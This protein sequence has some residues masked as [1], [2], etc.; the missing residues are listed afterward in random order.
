MH[1]IKL[2]IPDFIYP[3]I[4]S[5]LK[6]YP[7]ANIVEDSVNPDFIV[8]NMDEAKRRVQ[9]ARK[10]DNFIEEKQFWEEID[11]NIFFFSI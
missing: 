1:T 11:K 5:L 8:S 2:N 4:M 6:K 7:N 9:E 3:E 10:S